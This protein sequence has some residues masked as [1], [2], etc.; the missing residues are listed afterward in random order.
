MAECFTNITAFNPQNNLRRG[1]YYYLHFIDEKTVTQRDHVA[2]AGSTGS[3]PQSR[4]GAQVR[5]PLCCSTALGP[6]PWAMHSSSYKTGHLP[7]CPRHPTLS[8]SL[9][10][11]PA[12]M[13][14][15]S[16][17]LLSTRPPGLLGAL[18]GKAFPDGLPSRTPGS[19]CVCSPELKLPA[20]PGRC[21][22]V[23]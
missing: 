15:C 5:S 3:A 17:G 6:L 16:K 14:I 20:S 21:H 10:F 13:S 8:T 12:G 9:S 11:G 19:S 23:S 2:H 1:F 22:S 4:E 18:P 7:R